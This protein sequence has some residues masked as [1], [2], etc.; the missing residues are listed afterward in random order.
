[1]LFTELKVDNLLL[2][3]TIILIS[4][5]EVT[6]LLPHIT[7]TKQAI[8]AVAFA[9]SGRLGGTN[10]WDKAIGASRL[11]LLDAIGLRRLAQEGVEI[12]AHSRTHRP[13][14]HVAVEELSNEIS[15]SVVPSFRPK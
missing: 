15:G 8:P 1:M 9:V 4:Q 11:Q 14:T 6:S 10:D 12:G 3:F 13:L 7:L 2:S 5:K